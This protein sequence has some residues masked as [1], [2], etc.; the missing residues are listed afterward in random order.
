[1]RVV[2][3]VLTLT[4]IGLFAGLAS[5]LGLLLWPEPDQP[6]ASEAGPHRVQIVETRQV[7]PSSGVPSDLNLAAANNNLDAVRHSDGFVYLAFRNAPHHFASPET[8]ILVL[9]SRDE[10]QWSFEHSFALGTDLREPRLLSVGEEL[11][12]YVSRLGA[13]PLAFEPQGMS[14]SVRS[15]SGEWSPLEP[16]GPAGSIAWRARHIA[17]VPALLSYRGGEMTYRFSPP[18]Q[19]ID[20]WRSSNG[21]DWK[22]WDP[23]YGAVYVGGGGEADFAQAGSGEFYAVI[24][25]EAGD[26]HGWG[27]RLCSAPQEHPARWACRS[28]L[29]KYDS[30]FVFAHEGVVYAVARRNLRGNGHFDRGVGPAR[31]PWRWLRSVWN[32]LSYSTARKRCALWRFEPEGPRLAFVL[33]LPSQ[34]DTCFPAVLAGSKPGE[35]IVYDYSSPLSAP[36]PRWIEGQRGETRIYRHALE[37]RSTQGASP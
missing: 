18:Q 17:G 9:R 13:D 25:A 2:L 15:T 33:D 8:R 26:E 5:I 3:R 35:R 23:D 24:R 10:K 29:R 11:V 28:D 31:G 34:G 4:A 36:D 27:S 21:R 32:Q 37:F 16:F 14:L 20:L 12:L 19:R 30:P 6:I 1:M 22:L 7:I